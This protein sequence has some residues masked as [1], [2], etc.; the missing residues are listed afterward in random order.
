MCYPQQVWFQDVRAEDADAIEAEVK[1]IL[2]AGQSDMRT[3]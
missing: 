3:S 2:A 1:R